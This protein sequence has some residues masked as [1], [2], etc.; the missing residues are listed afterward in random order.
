MVIR[1]SIISNV[2]TD[3]RA[4]PQCQSPYLKVCERCQNKQNN[5]ILKTSATI[6]NYRQQQPLQ[7]NAIRH[8]LTELEQK[9]NKSSGLSVCT[10]PISIH[11]HIKVTYHLGIN[12]FGRYS[13]YRYS[14]YHPFVKYICGEFFWQKEF[15]IVI[16]LEQ[17]VSPQFQQAITLQSGRG[18]QVFI[19]SS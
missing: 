11:F 8:V 13:I 12:I 9:V 17:F 1:T 5:C 7:I 16:F 4:A 18:K 14:K 2:G 15:H 3:T 19:P 6:F 10:T